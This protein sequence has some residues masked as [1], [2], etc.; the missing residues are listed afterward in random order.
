[1][2]AGEPSIATS[3]RVAGHLV[4][5]YT[6]EPGGL[7]WPEV[8]EMALSVI[9]RRRRR[10]GPR[11]RRHRGA[12]WLVRFC[13]SGRSP[14]AVPVGSSS[15]AVV[16]RWRS[17]FA[18][19][20]NAASSRSSSSR[21]RRLRR[22]SFRPPGREPERT[23][24]WSSA[25]CVRRIRPA[26]AAR[27]TRPTAL[28]WRNND[29]SRRH[30]PSGPGGP[31]GR[32]RPAGAGVA[33]RDAHVLRLLL[34]PVQEAAQLGAEAQEALVVTVRQSLRCHATYIVLRYFLVRR[35]RP[36]HLFENLFVG[37]EPRVVGLVV[38]VGVVSG[39]VGALYLL[40][41]H[42]LQNVCGRPNGAA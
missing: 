9:E 6:R 42:L 22:A 14:P 41:L 7:T 29:R 37:L 36:S 18:P 11:R 20:E 23:V 35:L 3:T 19:R 25:S 28:W 5:R 40:V 12:F 24:R 8:G 32:A 26:S 21:W 39:I 17:A 31:G 10:G 4:L 15:L 27:S 34:A 33:R 2:A 16:N 30:P 38:I 1:M 13:S